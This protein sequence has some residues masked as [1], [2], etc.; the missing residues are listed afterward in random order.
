MSILYRL[1]ISKFGILIYHD[2]PNKKI[3]NYIFWRVYGNTWR[4]EYYI[5]GLSGKMPIN[6]ICVPFGYIQPVESGINIGAGRRCGRQNSPSGT[7]PEDAAYL[8][9]FS[10]YSIHISHAAMVFEERMVAHEKWHKYFS[11]QMTVRL[12]LSQPPCEPCQVTRDQLL[13][14]QHKVLTSRRKH[15]VH[16]VNFL[17]FYKTYKN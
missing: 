14:E 3:C 16:M 8:K 7:L 6:R 12:K 2:S 15:A 9:I 11:W 4:M 10:L 13:P 1:N 17:K 5:L